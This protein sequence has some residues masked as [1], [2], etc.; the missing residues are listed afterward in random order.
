[1]SSLPDDPVA[2]V[3]A[4]LARLGFLPFGW[5]EP[6]SAVCFLGGVCF[7]RHCWV[8]LGYGDPRARAG[9]HV[10]VTTGSAGLV[11]EGQL[12]AAAYERLAGR[13]APRAQA[14]RLRADLLAA[15]PGGGTL[16]VGGAAL[17]A[18]TAATWAGSIAW[19]PS[20]GL[21]VLVETYGLRLDALSLEPVLDLTPYLSGLPREW[22]DR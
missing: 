15:A 3:G 7:G 13:T 9:V 14:S 17:A 5:A 18:M 11:E 2:K 21:A 1:V 12:L 22:I 8:T 19:A 6:G 10:R 20:D 16:R 4:Q